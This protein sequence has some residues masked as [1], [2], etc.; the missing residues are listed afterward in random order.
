[1]SDQEKQEY[2]M[3]DDM[4][5]YGYS[6]IDN[7]VIY[8]KEITDSEFRTYCVIRSLVNERKAVAWPSYETIAELSG[9]SK[10]TAM[11]NVARLIELDLIE[12]RPRSGTSN[13][14][15]VKKLQNSKVLKN[16]QDILDYIEK[17]RDD[18]PK[19]ATDPGEKVDKPE[20]A[21]P[22]PYKEIIDYLNEKAGTKYSHTGSANQKLIKARWNEMAK[23]NKDRDWIVAQFKHVIDV[24]TAQWKGTEW[25][26]YL[27]PSTLF[28]NKF[29]Q[30]RN[31]SPN[32]KPVGGQNRPKEDIRTRLAGFLA[33]ED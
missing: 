29:D 22:I 14:F 31:E 4:W 26:K 13:E 19:K 18:E 16:K 9:H 12:K 32:H 21:D 17:C 25:E 28:G 8:S 11:R 3:S 27:R 23:I 30:Y 1:M 10:R 5:V 24:K 20:K 2:L 7:G 6:V 33:D 15:V